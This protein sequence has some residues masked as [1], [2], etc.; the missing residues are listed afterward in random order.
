M[1]PFFLVVLIFLNFPVKASLNTD[2]ID[3]IMIQFKSGNT[4][5]I[6]K[7]FASSLELLIIDQ[8]E[9]YS[10]AQSEQI[11][12]D[13]FTKNPP[14][15]TTLIHKLLTNP[16]YKHGVFSLQSKTGVYRVSITYSKQRGSNV[17]LISELRI[18]RD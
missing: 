12:K 15:K 3:D 5:E 4:K 13:F 7:S 11:L 8:E 9:V 6:A 2:I 1:K 10:K 16:N 14:L 18:Q 17:F